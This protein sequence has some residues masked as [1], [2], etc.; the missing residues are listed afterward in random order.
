VPGMCF[1][2][3][4]GAYLAG[5][6]GVGIEDIVTATAEGGRRLNT[7]DQDCGP[8]SRPGGGLI[9]VSGD[10][11]L[12]QSPPPKGWGMHSQRRPCWCGAGLALQ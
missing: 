5:R 7:T 3:E 8:S 12:C 6:F 11:R 1:S 2:V 10:V 9:D 4:P